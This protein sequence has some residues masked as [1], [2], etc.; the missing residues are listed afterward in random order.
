V[1]VGRQS[2]TEREAEEQNAQR[3]ARRASAAAAWGDGDAQ[4]RQRTAMVIAAFMLDEVREDQLADWLLCAKPEHARIV[5]TCVAVCALQR[6]ITQAWDALF[7]GDAMDMRQAED[8]FFGDDDFTW[9]P[10]PGMLVG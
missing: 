6:N 2:R 4:T 9:E 3:E 5:A 8:W 10:E 7:A 1:T